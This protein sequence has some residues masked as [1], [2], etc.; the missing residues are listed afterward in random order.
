[1][2]EEKK[3]AQTV[4]EQAE[5]QASDAKQAA[6]ALLQ[7]T[8]LHAADEVKKAQE[9][10]DELKVQAEQAAEDLLEAHRY[11]RHVA[12]Y[13]PEACLPPCCV[14]TLSQCCSD[15]NVTHTTMAWY[16]DACR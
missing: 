8:E 5:K 10:A 14:L 4:R 3:T 15:D 7:G 6:D 11:N 12:Q 13:Y 16:C 9:A 1:M 2:Q